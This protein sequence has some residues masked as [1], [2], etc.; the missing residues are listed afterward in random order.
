MIQILH[1]YDF[2]IKKNK[3]KHSELYVSIILCEHNK[4]IDIKILRFK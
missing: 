3:N 4:L 1:V 2:I